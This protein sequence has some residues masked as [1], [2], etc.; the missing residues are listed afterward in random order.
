MNI[1]R[2][3][4]WLIN[5]AKIQRNQYKPLESK[6]D[7]MQS[8]FTDDPEIYVASADAFSRT[9]DNIKVLNKLKNKLNFESVDY[10]YSVIGGLSGLNYLNYVSPKDIIFFD[11][12]RASVRYAKLIFNLIQISTT[13]KEFLER[14]FSRK[15]EHNI[16]YKNQKK[17]ISKK[18]SE[19][20]FNDTLNRLHPD[21]RKMFLEVFGQIFNNCEN[22]NLRY[23]KIVLPTLPKKTDVPVNTKEPY[24]QNINTLHYGYGWLSSDEKFN[25]IRERIMSIKLEVRNL[26]EMDFDHESKNIVIFISNINRFFPEEWDELAIKLMNRKQRTLVITTYDGIYYFG[27]GDY[28]V[29]RN[30]TLLTKI[31]KKIS[32]IYFRLLKKNKSTKPHKTAFEK[33]KPYTTGKVIELTH[34]ND[35]GF[36]ELNSAKI[37]YKNY[38]DNPIYVDTILLHNLLGEGVEPTYFSEVLSVAIKKTKRI[39]ILEHNRSSKDWDECP[40]KKKRLLS[41]EDIESLFPECKKTKCF[42]EGFLDDKRNVIYILDTET[43]KGYNN[44][45]NIRKSIKK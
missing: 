28:Y 39:V 25:T 10:F 14:F 21:N 20:L 30:E 31:F 15:M 22:L 3:P 18:P 36:E 8:I 5:Y 11:I 35:W 13:R 17:Y 19:E 38:L 24:G 44:A 1:L 45:K 7:K 43:L 41:V 23:C 42:S 33:I 27:F 9:E 16:S 4:T 12:N 32:P 29:Y 34:R 37:P 26:F 2:A 40:L 6:K